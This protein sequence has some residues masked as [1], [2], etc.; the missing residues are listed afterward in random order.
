MDEAVR[1][2]ANSDSIEKLSPQQASAVEQFVAA[3]NRLA[4]EEKRNSE[5]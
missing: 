2:A 1:F 5:K 4:D 3:L